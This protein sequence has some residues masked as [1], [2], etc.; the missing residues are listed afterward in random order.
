MRSGAVEL[1]AARAQAAAPHFAPGPD[2]VDAIVEVFGGSTDS[3]G[4]RLAR[5]PLLGVEG[6][7]SRLGERFNVLTAGSRAVPAG[8]GPRA[9]LEGSHG[10]LTAER[11]V[12]RRGGSLATTLKRRNTS[13]DAESMAGRRSITQRAGGQVAGARGGVRCR[14]TGFSRRRAYALERLG[15]AGET[16]PPCVCMPRR[17]SNGCR[18]WT[19]TSCVTPAVGPRGRPELDSLRRARLTAS[20]ATRG[21][22]IRLAAHSSSVWH[23]THQLHEAWA[24]P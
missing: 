1:F 7:R 23:A 24:L 8:T 21:A 4:H 5:V 12:F 2:N 22:A 14:A 9:T 17:C 16:R 18:R 13:R 20:A 10:L 11:R 19:T 6:L 15:G 3:A